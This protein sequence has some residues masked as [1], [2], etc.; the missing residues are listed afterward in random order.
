MNLMLVWPGCP[1][2]NLI[3]DG[4][5]W[6]YSATIHDA[7]SAPL[8]SGCVYPQMRIATEY[9]GIMAGR[10]SVYYTGTG[11]TVEMRIAGEVRQWPIEWVVAEAMQANRNKELVEKCLAAVNDR[12]PRIIDALD[13]LETTMQNSD[14]YN[15]SVDYLVHQMMRVYDVLAKP[16]PLV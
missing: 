15:V 10:F 5:R 16:A 7:G 12:D 8:M 9:D 1:A 2:Y 6:F 11:G 14:P 13:I 4:L 3:S